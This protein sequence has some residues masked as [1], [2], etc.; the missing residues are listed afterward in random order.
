MESTVIDLKGK[1]GV[2]IHVQFKN[3]QPL[4]FISVTD[5]SGKVFFYKRQFDKP[6]LRLNL[7]MHPDQVVMNVAGAEIDKYVIQPLQKI[8]FQYHHNKD[9]VQTRNYDIGQ[10]QRQTLPYFLDDKG[11]LNNSPARFFPNYGVLQYNGSIM[12][13][14]PQPVA[15]FVGFHE[16]GHYYYGRPIPKVIAQGAEEF[17]HNQLKEDEQEA[18]RFALYNFINEGYNFSGALQSLSD[19]LSESYISQARIGRL[20]D[21]IKK[22]HKYIDY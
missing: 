7:P 10:I 12:P 19:Y 2:T 13:Q 16:L 20:G 4:F 3:I 11:Q 18:D 8:S 15:T 14:L 6:K 1:K 5:L 9:L 21:E 17:Y 22:M